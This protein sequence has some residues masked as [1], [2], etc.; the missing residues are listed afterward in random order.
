MVI[1]IQSNDDIFDLIQDLQAEV[2]GLKA[3]ISEIESRVPKKKK[4]TK[5][6]PSEVA[7]IRR[8]FLESFEKTFGHPYVGLGAKEN[9]MIKTWL[10]SVPFERALEMSMVYPKWK[11]KHVVRS[12]HPFGLLIAKHVE[13]DAHMCRYPQLVQDIIKSRARETVEIIEK[14][15]DFEVKIHAELQNRGP[16]NLRIET[17]CNL[18]LNQPGEANVPLGTEYEVSGERAEPAGS[19]VQNT[20]VRIKGS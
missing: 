15:K 3:R 17:G 18:E 9:G 11:E 10:K 2:A 5:D 8:A 12:G 20:R 14:S 19:Q 1:D 4:S 13:L 7:L 6:E 16:E